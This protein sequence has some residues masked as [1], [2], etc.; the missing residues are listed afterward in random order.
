MSCY[1]SLD[2][3]PE[4]DKELIADTLRVKPESKKTF[5][6]KTYFKKEDFVY[7]YEINEETNHVF[8]PYAWSRQN[9]SYTIIP[10]KSEYMPIQTTFKGTLRQ[11]QKEVKGDAIKQLN[12]TGS[13][14]LALHVGFGKTSLAI[15]LS[16]K[17]GLKTVILCHRLELIRQFEESLKDFTNG[18]KYQVLQSNKK[19]DKTCDYYIIN[20]LNVPKF[21]WIFQDVGLV[22]VDEIHLIATKS[23]IKSL[24]Y[25]TPKYLIGLSATPTRPDGMDKLLDFYFGEFCIH[26]K[27][28]RPHDYYVLH[29]KLK[30][31]VERTESG[32]INWNSVIN[33]QTTCEERNNIILNVVNQFKDRN[34]LI[35][36]KRLEQIQYLYSKLKDIDSVDYV[37][38][39]KLTFDKSVRILCATAQKC[40]VGFSFNKLDMLIVAVDFEEYFIQYLGRIMRTEEGRPL[41]VDLVDEY[42]TLKN[43]HKT[44]KTVSIES[45]GD[46]K[47]YPF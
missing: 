36:C 12:Q 42:P 40:G 33:W 27:L 9:L 14:K 45:G 3:I 22:I 28:F 11:G 47:K 2:T 43:H 39:E 13:V 7:P 19:V 6:K 32:D 24:S 29:T 46:Y 38:G 18:C 25:F 1:F 31:V 26:K 41:V 44:R 8:L 34:I 17:I 23:L 20:P 37:D 4:T 5:K 15:Y 10:D 16:T 35:L 21:G 30:P